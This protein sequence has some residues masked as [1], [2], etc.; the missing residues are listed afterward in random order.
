M[1]ER[2]RKERFSLEL[3]I[4]LLGRS[5][6]QGT[7]KNISSAGVSFNSAAEVQLGQR[8]EFSITLPTPAPDERT[9]LHGNGK[10]VRIQERRSARTTHSIASTIDRYELIRVPTIIQT[11]A[12][13]AG[14]DWR[15][16]GT[17]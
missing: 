15:I 11:C 14:T 6:G 13:I 10:V 4:T 5:I 12:N 1:T 16:K 7:T 3:P 9:V 2:R 17:G 8:I